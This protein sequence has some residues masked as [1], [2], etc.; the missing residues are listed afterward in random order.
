[1][2]YLAHIKSL[3]RKA[4]KRQKDCPLIGYYEA[5]HILPKCELKRRNRPNKIM[6]S[7]WNFI[8]LTAKEHFIMHLLYWK[9]CRK[10]YGEKHRLTIKMLHAVHSFANRKA[11]ELADYKITSRTYEI[12]KKEFSNTIKS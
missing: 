1:L 10:Y 11:C 3:I 7:S 9:F 2:N 6:N 8:Q 12:L 4:K 5:H